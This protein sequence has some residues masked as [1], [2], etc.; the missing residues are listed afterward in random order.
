M[1]IIKL[2]VY[3]FFGDQ[4]LTLFSSI[5]N[6]DS[7]KEE[8]KENDAPDPEVDRMFEE[9]FKEKTSPNFIGEG[10][11]L[12]PISQIADKQVIYCLTRHFG[13]S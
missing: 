5:F 8:N 2:L 3:L 9:I 12:Q 7:S 10:Y 11:A 13:K 1:E 6:S 4:G